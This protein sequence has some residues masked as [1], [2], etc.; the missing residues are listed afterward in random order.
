MDG[1]LIYTTAEIV[2]TELLDFEFI[3]ELDTTYRYKEPII[4]STDKK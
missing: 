3:R 2:I 1:N 4:K